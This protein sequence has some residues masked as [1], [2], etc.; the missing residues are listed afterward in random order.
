VLAGADIGVEDFAAAAQSSKDHKKAA[1][2]VK[3]GE[4]GDGYTY[5]FSEGTDGALELTTVDASGAEDGSASFNVRV[6]SVAKPDTDTTAVDHDHIITGHHVLSV[7]GQDVRTLGVAEVQEVIRAALVKSADKQAADDSPFGDLNEQ[8]GSNMELL[9]SLNIPGVGGVARGA[10]A[11]ADDLKAGAAAWIQLRLSP[12]TSLCAQMTSGDVDEAVTV[13]EEWAEKLPLALAAT[14][15]ANQKSATAAVD[16]TN[17]AMT[18]AANVVESLGCVLRP[19]VLHRVTQELAEH[20]LSSAE[21]HEWLSMKVTGLR[22]QLADM[23]LSS[24]T[25]DSDGSAED[26]AD[27]TKEADSADEADT[28][29]SAEG[30]AAMTPKERAHRDFARGIGTNGK[31]GAGTRGAH[32]D[33]PTKVQVSRL[34]VQ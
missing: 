28:D 16:K 17:A 21:Y 32:E 4:I 3:R 33:S 29:D 12:F 18:A 15:D 5:S 25:V 13:L 7:S 2:S 26:D 1:P 22:A 8:F 19:S 20:G 6:A 31:I 10:R 14:A 30:A 9:A 27:T 24:I 23:V 34:Q 11:P